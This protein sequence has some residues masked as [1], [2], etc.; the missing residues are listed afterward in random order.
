MS[1]WVSR[2]RHKNIISGSFSLCFLFSGTLL[3]KS[4]SSALR[5][6]PKHCLFSSIRPPRFALSFSMCLANKPLCRQWGGVRLDLPCLFSFCRDHCP[7]LLFNFWKPLVHFI[8]HPRLDWN[9]NPYYFLVA[10]SRSF[11]LLILIRDSKLPFPERFPWLFQ[12]LFSTWRLTN[13]VI[14]LQILSSW[15]WLP[16]ETMFTSSTCTDALQIHS[17]F[18]RSVW[19]PLF[20]MGQLIKTQG[21][22]IIWQ[23]IIR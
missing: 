22:Y 11:F 5:P 19:S 12:F 15:A 9:S 4:W 20:F 1:R 10:R 17:Q 14:P 13:G 23:G 18:V 2:Q 7:V 21:G 6:D 3:W 16:T 8:S